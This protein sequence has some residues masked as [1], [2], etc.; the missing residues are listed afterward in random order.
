M[1][2]ITSNDDF[3]LTLSSN[4]SEQFF[5]SNTIS[6]FKVQLPYQLE[7]DGN[8]EVALVEANMPSTWHDVT[9][10]CYF[11]IY[12]LKKGNHI[13]I[14]FAFIKTVFIPNGNYHILDDIFT[15][16]NDK[17]TRDLVHYE[18][19]H[20]NYKSI[21]R[22]KKN[23]QVVLSK[24]L[25]GKL[26]FIQTEFINLTDSHA[27]YD[28]DEEIIIKQNINSIY[29]YSSLIQPQIVSNT[30]SPLLRVIHFDRI[31]TNQTAIIKEFSKPFY[32]PLLY[33]TFQVVEIN[34]RDIFGKLVPFVS[35]NPS[36]FVLHFRKIY[37]KL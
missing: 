15:I 13:D 22:L 26:G 37:L 17:D 1:N 24:D 34:I 4:S 27:Q 8:Y 18:I 3:Y 2:S 30:L 23:T 25:A 28:S 6:N 35:V 31:D 19:N 20:N 32:F 11:T 10:E 29:I 33:K 36:I 5:K 21:I 9:K 14:S 7:L 12:K 16:L